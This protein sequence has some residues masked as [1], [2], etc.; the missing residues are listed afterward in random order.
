MHSGR[1]DRSYRWLLG[2]GA[3]QTWHRFRDDWHAQP[4]PARR[5]LAWT[6]TGGFVI[7]V[8]VML[9][10]VLLVR[11]LDSTGR[12]AWETPLVERAGTWQWFSFS[13]ALW[14]ESP[15]NSVFM[16]PVVLAAA[17]LAVWMRRPLRALAVL[18]SFFML[19]LV[20]LAGW[21]AWNRQRPGLIEGGIA[22]PGLHSFP[23]GHLS[24]M[25]AAYG[26]FTWMWMRASRSL[27]E[28]ILAVLPL[29]LALADVALARL[30]LG[31]HWPTDLAAGVVIGAVWLAVIIT[32]L[33]RAEA[34]GGR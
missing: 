22:A 24:Q 2:H 7:A 9:G 15:G 33:R 29:A 32:A 18:A 28:R 1:T 30:R 25:V 8:A 3:R 34:A 11:H 20:V 27:A 16:I 5:R 14:A 31:S 13:T 23:S 6:I 26:L 12:L 19:D 10:L 4:D 17:L 21:L